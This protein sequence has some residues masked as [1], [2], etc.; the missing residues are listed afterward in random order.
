MEEKNTENN[1]QFIEQELIATQN[2][3]EKA[4]GKNPYTELEKAT[5]II[6]QRNYNQFGSAKNKIGDVL[7]RIYN[8]RFDNMEIVIKKLDCITAILSA[9]I[10]SRK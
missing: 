4:L 5:K 9:I 1:I 10:L 3:I 2:I 7:I 8:T 6:K